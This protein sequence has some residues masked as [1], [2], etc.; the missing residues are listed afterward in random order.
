MK[1]W[2]FLQEANI[3]NRQGLG[4]VPDNQNVDYLGLRV[5]MKPSPQNGPRHLANRVAHL[6]TS[7]QQQHIAHEPRASTPLNVDPIDKEAIVHGAHLLPNAARHQAA[8]GDDVVY[9]IGL[10][11]A[12][13]EAFSDPIVGLKRKHGVATLVVNG[14]RANGGNLQMLHSRPCPARLQFAHHAHLRLAV[15]IEG[16]DSFKAILEGPSVACIEGRG[17]TQILGKFYD[18]KHMGSARRFQ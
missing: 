6:G 12:W 10:G 1:L 5:Q 11:L 4:N 3:D 18:A 2:D 17:H 16:D 9:M 8:R 13:Q 15:L 7:I 14:G